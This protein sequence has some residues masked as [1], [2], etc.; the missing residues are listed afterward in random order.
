MCENAECSR[1]S[2][3]RI[4]PLK[5]RRKAGSSGCSGDLVDTSS[6]V[7]AGDMKELW[8]QQWWCEG[9]WKFPE[10]RMELC[11]DSAGNGLMAPGRAK[12]LDFLRLAG[13][14]RHPDRAS[15]L[16]S[17]MRSHRKGSPHISRYSWASASSSPARLLGPGPPMVQ[18][19][20]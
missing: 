16:S 1:P 4:P 9:P 15:G 20:A 17:L 2:R 11:E 18:G 12:L 14:L 8:V 5:L 3:R 19:P 13:A 10:S 7:E 6:G